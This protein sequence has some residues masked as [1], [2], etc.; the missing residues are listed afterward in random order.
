[1]KATAVEDGDP[2]PST[3]GWWE[4]QHLKRG[5]SASGR[6]FMSPEA[7]ATQN[8]PKPERPDDPGNSA[9]PM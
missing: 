7:V 5:L 6:P 3:D 1:M 8:K 2:L 9:L 4:K